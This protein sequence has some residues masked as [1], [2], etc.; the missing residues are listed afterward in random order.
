MNIH[1]P[2]ETI[3][4]IAGALLFLLN[5]PGKFSLDYLLAGKLK[6]GGPQSS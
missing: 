2:S 6:P 4:W 5:S 1:A 3:F